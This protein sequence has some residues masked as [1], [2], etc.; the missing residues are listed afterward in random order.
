MARPT[1]IATNCR[2]R[3]KVWRP[4]ARSCLT[5]L[6]LLIS[7]AE[8]QAGQCRELP[9]ESLTGNKNLKTLAHARGRDQ[10]LELQGDF[11]AFLRQAALFE[12]LSE[13]VGFADAHQELG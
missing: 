4:I 10:V 8:T 9:L 13:L 6:F 7:L 12:G 2:T 1:T 11:R 3:E 5:D